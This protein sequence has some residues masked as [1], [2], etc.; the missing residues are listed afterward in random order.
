MD[1]T[2]FAQGVYIVKLKSSNGSE[3]TVRIIKD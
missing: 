2:P 3:K 1:I